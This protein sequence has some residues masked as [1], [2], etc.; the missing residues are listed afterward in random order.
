M[1]YFIYGNQTP[2]IIKRLSAIVKEKLPEKD[3]M[4]YVRYDGSNTLIQEII[5]DANSLPLG[6]DHKIVVVDSCYFLVKPKTRNKIEADQDYGALKDFI[7]H[8]SDE[9]D[10]VLLASS[11]SVDKSDE[12]YKL[13]QEKG[14]ILEIVD[15]DAEQWKE[16]VRRYVR[17]AKGLVIDNDALYELE[18]R[19]SGDV[20]L[21]QNSV[22]KLSL[23]TDHITYDDIVL[24]VTRPLDDNAFAL[25]ND[26][27]QGKNGQAIALFRDLQT[28]NVEPVTLIGMLANQFR[29]LNE[30]SFL[31]RNG[32][33]KD[34][35]AKELAIKPI[36]AQILLRNIYLI[37]P[38]T[39]NETLDA[40]FNLDLQIKSGLVDRY[41]AFELF[42]VN[43]KRS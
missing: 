39:I 6:Y 2:T 18:E 13:I 8:P 37:S 26:L 19:T 7:N 11:L 27:L 10:L 9:C 22:A 23:Y 30:I 4:N 17:E 28:A 12:I 43:F 1:V 29:L 3:E 32:Y 35:I 25:F 33:G 5:D 21:L 34:D 14:K 41:Y 36:R 15:P 38:D 24:M 40:L 31:S 20:A 16:Y 42:L